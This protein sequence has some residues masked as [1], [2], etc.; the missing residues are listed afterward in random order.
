MQSLLPCHVHWG[1]GRVPT[2]RG[3]HSGYWWECYGT[4]HRLLLHIAHHGWGGERSDTLTRCMSITAC[5]DTGDYRMVLSDYIYKKIPQPTEVWCYYQSFGSTLL[6][7]TWFKLPFCYIMCHLLER[8]RDSKVI[9]D[10]PIHIIHAVFNDVHEI[11]KHHKYVSFISKLWHIFF[12]SFRI[13][14]VNFSRDNWTQPTALES[15]HLQTH[16]P[17]ENFCALPISSHSTILWR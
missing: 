16:T 11:V 13:Y 9:S 15:E 10:V 6:L 1:A 12:I 4:A 8:A 5:R 14:A 7:V 17:A 2:N 3:H